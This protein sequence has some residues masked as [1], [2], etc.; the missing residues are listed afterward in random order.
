MEYYGGEREREG[1]FALSRERSAGNAF[2]LARCSGSSGSV[3]SPP[4][5]LPLLGEGQWDRFTLSS[6]VRAAGACVHA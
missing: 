4:R 5:D 3:P 1:W 2:C 6:P